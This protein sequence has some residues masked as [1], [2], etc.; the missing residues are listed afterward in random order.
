[1]RRDALAL[2]PADPADLSSV[3]PGLGAIRMVTLVRAARARTDELNLLC[4]YAALLEQDP[5]GQSQIEM[6]PQRDVSRSVLALAIVAAV[7]RSDS[8]T[9]KIG[10]ELRRYLVT[11]R[12]DA[13]TEFCLELRCRHTGRARRSYRFPHDFRQ[14]S[15]PPRVHRGRP[16]RFARNEKDR[17]AV[18]RTHADDD[19]RLPRDERVGFLVDPPQ[20]VR[21]VRR[22]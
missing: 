2:L 8:G 19:S 6:R 15:A 13:R 11:A 18:G 14:R 10:G 1:D 17:N 9:R 22:V 4:G 12:A 16:P 7:R 20:A 3:G 21:M 5:V